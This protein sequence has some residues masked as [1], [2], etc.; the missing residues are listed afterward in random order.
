MPSDALAARVQAI[1]LQFRQRAE[2]VAALMANDPQGDL[3][4]CDDTA[5]CIYYEIARELEDA[6]NELK[7]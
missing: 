1:I 2:N 7:L 6:L 3:A 4:C 5:V